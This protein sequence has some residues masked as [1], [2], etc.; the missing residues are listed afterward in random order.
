MVGCIWEPEAVSGKAYS[1]QQIWHSRGRTGLGRPGVVVRDCEFQA[2]L[3]H[4]LTLLPNKQKTVKIKRTRGHWLFWGGRG[5]W[6]WHNALRRR[7]PAAARIGAWRAAQVGTSGRGRPGAQSLRGPLLPSARGV[8]ARSQGGFCSSRGLQDL[9]RPARRGVAWGGEQAP[10]PPVS[11][12]PTPRGCRA[13][14]VP[15]PAAAHSR[16]LGTPP[17]SSEPGKLESL[18]DPERPGSGQGW[19]CGGR[20]GARANERRRPPAALPPRGPGP[21]RASRAA[22]TPL[23]EARCGSPAMLGGAVPRPA[24]G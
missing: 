13:P 11:L 8:S 16:R 22:Q 15:T 6:V 5:G 7:R 14:R 21:E 4:I 10:S 1:E 23:A 3:G 20:A 18:A 17:P 9:A 2:S 12:A 19:R 24:R